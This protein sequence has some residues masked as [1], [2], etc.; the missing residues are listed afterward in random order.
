[1]KLLTPK[2]GWTATGKALYWT[3][4]GGSTWKN[5]TPPS[6]S[7][8]EITSVFFLNTTQGWVLSDRNEYKYKE[9]YMAYTNDSGATWSSWPVKLLPDKY[10]NKDKSTQTT[11]PF[12]GDGWIEFIDVMRGW[13]ILEFPITAKMDNSMGILLRTEDGGKTY[14]MVADHTQLPT[15]GNFH[16]VTTQ[17]GWL[18]GHL[19]TNLFVTYNGGKTWQEVSLE[20]PP[21]I[22]SLGAQYDLPIFKDNQNGYLPLTFVTE[23]LPSLVLLVT[24]D[25][26][27]TW[28]VDRVLSNLK[29]IANVYP[30]TMADSLLITLTASDAERSLTLVKVLPDGKTITTKAYALDIKGNL[31]PRSLYFGAGWHLTFITP[32]QGWVSTYTNQLLST[33]DG[34]KTWTVIT[35]Q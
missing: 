14:K 11:N 29:D 2:I 15:T 5:I 25:G 3:T 35:P 10:R 33:S 28:K 20:P 34:G 24:K 27:K 4:N 26:G 8:G 23:D 1:M 21:Q 13:I 32:D 7:F 12:R 31:T 22:S 30:S 18:A 19:N 17:E 9:F 16:F 6:V